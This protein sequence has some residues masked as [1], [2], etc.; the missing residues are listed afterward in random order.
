[1]SKLLPGIDLAEVLEQRLPAMRAPDLLST[2]K[3]TRITR[4]PVASAKRVQLKLR[5][6]NVL[7]QEQRQLSIAADLVVGDLVQAGERIRAL[8][9]A[10]RSDLDRVLKSVWG[11][12]FA[13]NPRSAGIS[14][15]E[16]GVDRG[17]DSVDDLLATIDARLRCWRLIRKSTSGAQVESYGSAVVVNGAWFHPSLGG[18]PMVL[19]C[20]HVCSDHA[21]STPPKSLLPSEAAIDFVDSQRQAGSIPVTRL[22]WESPRHAL[23]ASL[24]EV[25]S[26]PSWSAP[27]DEAPSTETGQNEDIY[28]WAYPRNG[29]LKHEDRDGVVDDVKDPHF[30]YKMP[31][32][33]GFSGGPVFD[34]G[35]HQ[36]VGIHRG[37][38]SVVDPGRDP[39]SRHAVFFELIL[40]AAKLE[41]KSKL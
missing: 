31:T 26:L 9:R 13:P 12:G 17:G 11:V 41:L 23:D 29:A 21:G 3:S 24:L 16:R 40:R 7:N 10:Q 25:A 35:T 2:L 37:E 4:D 32:T 38:S 19:T 1:M 39:A 20:A 5:D 22:L 36:L 30:F 27:Q 18:K 8:D 28:L 6:W 34:A 33:S 14:P 15:N